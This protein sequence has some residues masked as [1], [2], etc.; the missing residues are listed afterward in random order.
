MNWGL[1]PAKEIFLG[2]NIRKESNFCQVCRSGRSTRLQLAGEVGEGKINMAA[3]K[4]KKLK[5]T[6]EKKSPKAKPGALPTVPIGMDGTA[7]TEISVMANEEYSREIVR[8]AEKKY[9]FEKF[10]KMEAKGLKAYLKEGKKQ[11]VDQWHAIQ[12]LTAHTEMF[13]VR[14]LINIGTILNDIETALK[15]KSRYM[16]WLRKNFGHKHLRYWQQAKQLAKMGDFAVNNASLGKNRL[17]AFAR[18]K[19]ITKK[20]YDALLTRHP[21]NDTTDDHDGLLFKQHVDAILTFYRFKEAK[22]DFV[23]FKQAELI[24]SILKEAVPVKTATKIAKWLGQFKSDEKKKEWFENLILNHVQFPDQ[25]SAA[26]KKQV[27]LREHLA[28]LISFA[29]QGT[30]SG[31]AQLE[32]V[33]DLVDRDALNNLNRLIQLLAEKLNI[34]LAPP[35][36]EK[37]TSLQDR[38]R[39]AA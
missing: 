35:T 25:P 1:E 21:F 29:K 13:T 28:F 20:K 8:N 9:D 10:K 6:S 17:L 34:Q 11:V 32:A 22:V 19:S 5:K 3:A 24:A 39:R 2:A 37:V 31:A 23:D 15:T 27:K 14:F 16:A 12:A 30:L 4:L 36:S 18:I 38:K 7:H 26:K 33:R